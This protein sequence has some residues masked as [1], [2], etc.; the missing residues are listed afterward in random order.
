M[1]VFQEARLDA[2]P[3]TFGLV[4]LTLS[5]VALTDKSGKSTLPPITEWSET[6]RVIQTAE[7]WGSHGAWIT[8]YQPEFGPGVCDRFKLAEIGVDDATMAHHRELRERITSPRRPRQ[9]LHLISSRRA[10]PA[11]MATDYDSVASLAKPRTLETPLATAP[12]LAFASSSCPTI[13]STN[14][15]ID[16]VSRAPTKRCSRSR[17]TRVGDRAQVSVDATAHAHG[18]RYRVSVL[19]SIKHFRLCLCVSISSKNYLRGG[20]ARNHPLRRR[21]FVRPG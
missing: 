1:R 3:D 2:I 12:V 14:R 17:K 20:C 11:P 4:D 19:H 15:G 9:R 10:G 21:S 5:D 13:K 7:V 6:F 18:V 8:E 16:D